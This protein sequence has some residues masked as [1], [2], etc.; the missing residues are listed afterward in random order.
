LKFAK[1]KVFIFITTDKLNYKTG[2]T[3]KF[4]IFCI[5]SETKPSNPKLGNVTIFNPSGFEVDRVANVTFAKG[6]YKK[7]FILSKPTS[8]GDWKLKFETETDVSF[9]LKIVE[10]YADF[11]L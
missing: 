9:L 3:V 2:D 1:K 10:F 7:S 6:K 5:D 8:T 11:F 4:N